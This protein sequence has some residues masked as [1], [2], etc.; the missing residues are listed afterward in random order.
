MYITVLCDNHYNIVKLDKVKLMTYKL[1]GNFDKSM[2][3][4]NEHFNEDK[5][6]RNRLNELEKE[7]FYDDNQ[8]W[9]NVWNILWELKHG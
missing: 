3:I 8:L 1:T 4:K 2:I 5:D 7:H 9:I 6:Y